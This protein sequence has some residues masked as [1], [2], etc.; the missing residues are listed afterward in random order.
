VVGQARL[1]L[2][3]IG[4]PA[5]WK[6]HGQTGRA[7]LALAAGAALLWTCRF[8]LLDKYDP[9]LPAPEQ[10]SA[11]RAARLPSRL[12]PGVA[13]LL[14]ATVP[15]AA[16]AVG[17]YP[18]LSRGAFAATTTKTSNYLAT[19][20]TTAY[21]LG[22]SGA[23]D[24]TSS[25]VLPLRTAA[26]SATTLHNY[27]TDR[28]AA[29]G[30]LLAKAPLGRT[31]TS[32]PSPTRSTP[33]EPSRSASPSPTPPTMTWCSPTAPPATPVHSSSVSRPLGPAGCPNQ[34]GLAS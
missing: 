14:A 4:L 3:N 34:A 32:A 9:W 25:T 27:D 33:D 6:R 19:A 21:H 8:A 11:G 16:L 17:E 30:L 24:T 28:D 12:K 1:L 15:A 31:G 26:P 5:V 2:P 10:R 22:T 29:P 7:L 20:S 13:L 18:R 23:G